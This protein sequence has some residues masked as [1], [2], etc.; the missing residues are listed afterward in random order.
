MSD[1]L[2][3]DQA[4]EDTIQ[5]ITYILN[6][7][8]CNPDKTNSNYCPIITVSYYLCVVVVVVVCGDILTL[9]LY[10]TFSLYSFFFLLFFIF[11]IS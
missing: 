10:R 3:P 11:Y 5:L 6:E 8:G 1:Y 7:I 2:S 4:L 9:S